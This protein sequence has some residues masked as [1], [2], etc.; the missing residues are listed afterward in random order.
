[1]RQLMH[2]GHHHSME[3][4]MLIQKAIEESQK[5]SVNPD[6]MTY[7]QMLAL[8]EKLGSVAKGFTPEEIKLIPTVRVAFGHHELRNKR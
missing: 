7:E 1:M 3:E 5:E 6:N 8:G 4:Q 2:R